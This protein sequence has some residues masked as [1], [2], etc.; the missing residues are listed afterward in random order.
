MTSSIRSDKEFAKTVTYH[1]QGAGASKHPMHSFIVDEKTGYVRV[2]K[3][4][5][6]EEIAFYNLT[7]IA[8]YTN[9]TEAEKRL[10]LRIKVLDQNDC[11]PTFAPVNPG[12]VNESSPKDTYIMKITARDDDEP[13]HLNSKIKYTILDQQPGGEIMFYIDSEGHLYVQNLNLDR[14]TQDSYKL[15]IKGTDLDG[16]VNG[17]TGTGTVVV[18]ILDINDNLPVLEKDSY[19]GSIEENTANM[20]VMR[21]KAID[22][23]LEYTDNWLAQYEIISGNE[24]GYFSIETDPKTNEGVLMLNKA[25]D[26][27]ELQELDLKVAVAN[28]APFY[29]SGGE[30]GGAGGEG[31]GAGGE[32]GWAGGGGGGAG[33]GGTGTGGGFGITG[34]GYGKTYPVKISVKNQPEGPKFSPKVKAIP[35]SEDIKKINL[36]SV[37]GKYP[38]TDEDTK[39][40]AQNV[41]YAK[42]YDPDNWLIID[43]K[44]AEIKLNKIPDR[45]S[46]YVVNGTYLAEILCMTQDMPSKTSTGTIAIQ[47]E[48]FNDHCPQLTSTSQ[49]VCTDDDS[50]VITARDDDSYPNGVPFMFNIIPESAKEQWKVERLN[51]TTAILRVQKPLWPGL[52]EVTVEIKDQ[53]GYACPD[54]QVLNVKACT[55]T[56]DKECHS[57]AREAKGAVFGAPGIGLLLLG[58]LM[59]L[60]VPLLLLFCTCGGAGAGGIAGGF[61]DIPFDTKEHLI[62]Y[63]TEGQGEDKE[64]PLM[65]PA[66]DLDNGFSK[67]GCA[68]VPVGTGLLSTSTIGGGASSFFQGNDLMEMDYMTKRETIDKDQGSSFLRFERAEGD[69]YDG[70]ALPDYYLKD[71]FAQKASCAAGN[72]ATKED[73]LAFNFEGHGSPVGSV[74]CCS[75]LEADNDLEFLNN[76]GPKFKTLAEICRGPEVEPEVSVPPPQPKA[77]HTTMTSVVT[78]SALSVSSLPPPSSHVEKHVVTETS[79]TATLP[80]VTVR[81][82]AVIP[83]QAYV[84]QQPVYLAPTPVLQTTQYVMEPQVHSTVLVSELPS[85]SNM[86]TMYVVDGVPGPESMIMKERVVTGPAVGG[87]VSSSVGTGQVVREGLVGVNSGLVGMKNL[88]GSQNLILLEGA[89][90]GGQFLQNGTLQKRDLSGSQK[91]LLV[92]GQMAS[93]QVIPGGSSWVQ[94]GSLHRGNLSGSQ[95]IHIVDGQGASGLVVQTGTSGLTQGVL[96]AGQLSG[97]QSAVFA[98]QNVSSRPSGVMGLSGG[99]FQ[100]SG[101]PVS[102]KVITKEKKV[103]SLQKIATE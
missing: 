81:E 88:Y 56:V 44:T 66:A 11:K 64:V 1:L 67:T 93:G 84:I 36:K 13:G 78:N 58:L 77:E 62:A 103:V 19:E 86:Q 27:E 49:T 70:I 85:V 69:I 46:K 53:Q 32:G 35:L 18:N 91:I 71:F 55:C 30:G 7:G 99:S 9:G 24:A 94:Q 96:Q 22:A 31:G 33:G 72:E 102:E 16:A 54:K 89:G 79:R 37:I 75:L 74:G 42:G 14:E 73:L 4:L 23:D 61:A 12:A 6:R 90:S 10:D 5:D 17:N 98:E 40:P 39:K 63:H 80:S 68:P 52:H 65:H 26:Y 41:R 21:F 82:N 2:T 20:E 100:V 3:V 25:V 101:F 43:E 50:L 95:N 57:K 45:E 92:D 34:T 38:A 97:M 59:L 83:N 28:K 76:L 48:D 87:V 15:T 51:D 29:L 8:L 60:L 47:V